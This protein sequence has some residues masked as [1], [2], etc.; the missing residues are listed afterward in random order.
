MNYSSQHDIHMQRDFWLLLWKLLPRV[1]Q[2]ESLPRTYTDHSM[3]VLKLKLGSPHSAPFTWR[4]PPYSLIIVAFRE[5]LR[6]AIEE[7]FFTNIGMVDKSATVWETF[8]VSIRG[9]AIS[10]HA[11][12]L[13]SIQNS[14]V[15][16]DKELATLKQ[17]HR[18][19]V[20][21]GLF[22]DIKGKIDEYHEQAQQE[23]EHLG[24]YSVAHRYEER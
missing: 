13:R 11:G 5:E 23:V 2:C 20:D 24:K 3:V 9:V 19:M 7:F 4:F 21:L 12:V 15:K 22:G 6:Q 8:K 10:K 1:Q 18:V 17:Q 14:L 16:L